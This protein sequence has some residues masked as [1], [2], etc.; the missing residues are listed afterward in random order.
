MDIDFFISP[1]K[2]INISDIKAM[3][4]NKDSSYYKDMKRIFNLLDSNLEILIGP[5]SN[6]IY[7]FNLEPKRGNI[8][9]TIIFRTKV[10]APP[11]YKQRWTTHSEIDIREVTEVH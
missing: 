4:T 7:I 8:D 6:I 11:G 9:N 3:L 1:I 2:F 5:L 10:E